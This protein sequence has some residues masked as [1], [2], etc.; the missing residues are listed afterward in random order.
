MT[1]AYLVLATT[2]ALILDNRRT[3]RQ[4]PTVPPS[5]NVM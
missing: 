1:K 3:L 5:Y 4:L 2:T